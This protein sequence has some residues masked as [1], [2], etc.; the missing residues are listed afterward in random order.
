MVAV[1]R[2]DKDSGGRNIIGR[3]NRGMRK[4]GK[5]KQRDGRS[6]KDK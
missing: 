6:G 2:R 5:W 1:V 3:N 4:K